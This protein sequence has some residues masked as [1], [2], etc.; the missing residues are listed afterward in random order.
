MP[1]PDELYT[2]IAPLAARYGTPIRV[3]VTLPDGSFD[4]LTKPDRIGEVCMVIRRPNGALLTAIKTFYPPEAYRLPTGG[5]APGEPIETAL[6]RE[7]Q[8]ET[9]L[10]VTVRQFLAV[11]EYI[12]PSVKRADELTAPEHAAP[13]E[14]GGVSDQT[15]HSLFYTFAFLLDEIG[16][17][18]APQDASERLAGFREVL[19]PEL[20]AMARLLEQVA[21]TYDPEIGGNWRHWGIFRAIVHR[22]VYATLADATGETAHHQALTAI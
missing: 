21:D 15:H 11:I 10:A 3:S 17:V 13:L 20:P 7:V 5:I 9:G 16:G 22:V 19:P 2:Q 12:A 4:P 1:I 14:M 18:L 6:L 8:E